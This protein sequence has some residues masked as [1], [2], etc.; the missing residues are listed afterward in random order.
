[1]ILSGVRSL[2]GGRLRKTKQEWTVGPR[3]A[4]KSGMAIPPT[5]P[6]ERK[7]ITTM[8]DINQI[9]EE[10]EQADRPRGGG[11]REGP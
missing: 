6:I 3:A 1:M 11:A 5:R 2:S 10:L 4:D 8:A 7:D 9:V